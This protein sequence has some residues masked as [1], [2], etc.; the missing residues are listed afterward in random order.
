M[1][2]H[3]ETIA[4]TNLEVAKVF[5]NV[6]VSKELPKEI[7]FSKDGKDFTV[8]YHYPWL[9]ARCKICDKWGHTD[10]V[11]VQNG[12]RKKQNGEVARSPKAGN[13]GKEVHSASSSPVGID[14]TRVQEVSIVGNG[15]GDEEG[16]KNNEVKEQEVAEVKGAA[17]VNIWSSVSPARA[18]RSQTNT[19]QKG[20][21]KYIYQLRSIQCCALRKIQ[22]KRKY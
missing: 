9:P 18:G 14:E 22:R 21:Q 2:L 7:E 13:D 5:V 3:Q 1:R 20:K 10:K 11:C 15:S 17:D 19:P 6:D 12:K 4:C 16:I 8:A